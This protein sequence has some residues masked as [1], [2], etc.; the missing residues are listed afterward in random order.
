MGIEIT[1]DLL[2]KIYNNY[3]KNK[4]KI[5][6]KEIKKVKLKGIDIFKNNVKNTYNKEKYIIKN[7]IKKRN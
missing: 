3:D 2:K 6:Q 5:P 4:D 7:E 1:K